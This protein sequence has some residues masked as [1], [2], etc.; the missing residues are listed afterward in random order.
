MEVVHRSLWWSSPSRLRAGWRLLWFLLAIA[1]GAGLSTA[2]WITLGLPP[3]MQ[4][5]VVQPVPQLASGALLV[6]LALLVTRWLLRRF[7]GRGLSTIGLARDRSAW[8]YP[9]GL[10]G[11]AVVPALVVAGLAA[12]G[13]A[14]VDAAAVTPAGLLAATVPMMLAVLLLSAWEE[15]ALRGYPLQLLSEAWGPGWAA[16][17]TG[18]AFGLLHAG[19]PGANP[20]GLVLTAAGG[21]LLA[22]LVIRTGSLWLACGY[23]GG[24]NLT[25]AVALG[26]RDSGVEHG[27]SLLRTGLAGPAWL[28]GGAYGFEASLLTGLVELLVLGAMLACA[29]RLPGN[30]AAR[31]FFRGGDPPRRTGRTGEG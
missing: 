29:G 19:N 13:H 28:T 27:G 9:L 20:L 11:G 21:V 5:G 2:A 15:I 25:A 22:W 3:Q 1:V 18:L 14:R 17:A 23:H 12:A 30:P 16:A 31:P 7:E 24:W 10:L 8:G 26:L 4:R 6:T